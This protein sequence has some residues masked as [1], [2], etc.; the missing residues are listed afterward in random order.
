MKNITIPVYT[1]EELSDKA[2][3]KAYYDWRNG[4]LES[5]YAVDE[6]M[7]T[8]KEFCRIF[9]CECQIDDFQYDTYHLY[10]NNEMTNFDSNH[11]KGVRLAKYVIN[12]YSQY[13]YSPKKLYGAFK[14]RSHKTYESK[15]WDISCCPLTGTYCDESILS[16]IFEC[17]EYKT[18]FDSYESLIR[19]CIDSWL[20]ACHEDI[21]YF[22]SYDCFLE[23]SFTDDGTYFYQDGSLAFREDLQAV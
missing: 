12:N 2:K 3:E 22:E 7:E 14:D 10:C 9:D 11:V 13:L 16:P 20:K 19:S 1:F 6:Y 5:Q 17:I 18:L 4:E 21:E 8:L 15:A 23:S